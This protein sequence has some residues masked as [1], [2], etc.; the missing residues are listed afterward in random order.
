MTISTN[1]I[2]YL[3]GQFVESSQLAIPPT[4]AGFLLGVTIA[5]Q[6]RT[7]GGRPFWLSQH[8]QR[9]SNGLGLAGIKPGIGMATLY[10]ASQT[11]AKHNFSLHS[12]GEGDDIGI[13]IFVTPGAY[14]AYGVESDG[15]TVAIHT[16]PLQFRLW[17]ERYRTGQRAVISDFREIPTDC[18]PAAIKCRSR[19]HYYLASQAARER[20]TAAIPI[21]LDHDGFVAETPIASVLAYSERDGFSAPRPNKILPGISLA[22]VKQWAARRQ[23]PFR[24]RDLKPTDLLAADEVLLTSTPFC[25]TPLVSIDGS[26]VGHGNPGGIYTRL[27]DDWSRDVGVSITDQPMKF[28]S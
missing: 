16:Y 18:W 6:A 21:L 12:R 28:G 1:E 23:I 8:L 20:D 3:N 4:D 14:S 27:L 17:A 5:E 24:H 25:A 26:P 2:A 7:F 15:P 22:F 19:M 9:L 13:T 11:V 10:T